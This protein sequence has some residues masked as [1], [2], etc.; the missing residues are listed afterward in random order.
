M[1]GPDTLLERVMLE[2]DELRKENERLRAEL[3]VARAALQKITDLIDSEAD[4][5]LDDAIR[6]ANRALTAAI[7]K[8][9]P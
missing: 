3:A 4:D 9:E 8:G 5:P 7:R 2:R 6:I 1:I